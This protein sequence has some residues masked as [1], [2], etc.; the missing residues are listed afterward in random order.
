MKIDIQYGVTPVVGDGRQTI[1]LQ[2]P[3]TCHGERLLFDLRDTSLCQALFEAKGWSVC[4][5]RAKAGLNALTL[6]IQRNPY[7]APSRES[8]L[9]VLQDF[10]PK[11]AF[12]QF[13]EERLTQSEMDSII[14][15]PTWEKLSPAKPPVDCQKDPRDLVLTG[16]RHWMG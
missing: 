6:G 16:K 10:S 1:C 2:V 4:C 13:A 14:C 12:L 5:V 9:H 11:G 15:S 7:I 3:E 8:L